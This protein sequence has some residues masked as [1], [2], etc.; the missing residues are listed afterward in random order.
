MSSASWAESLFCTPSLGGGG[1]NF[2]TAY[3]EVSNVG[4]WTD[5]IALTAANLDAQA[6]KGLQNP[7]IGSIF[8]VSS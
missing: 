6:S 8:G 1:V 7:A 5:D 2:V 3:T 4:Q